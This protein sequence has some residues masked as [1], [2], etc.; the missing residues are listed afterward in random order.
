VELKTGLFDPETREL[1]GPLIPRFKGR[2]D[3]AEIVTPEEGGDATIVL[4]CESTSRVLT[5]RRHDTR[6]QGPAH[7]RD[8]NDDLYRYTALQREK[9]IYFGRKAPR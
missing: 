7:Q 5:L 1:I 9:P 8:P 6:A 3:D 2:I 4:T